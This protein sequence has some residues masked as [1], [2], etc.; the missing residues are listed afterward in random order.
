M[1]RLANF[2]GGQSVAPASGKYVELISPVTGLAFAE[3]PVSNEA[4]VDHAFAVAS[5]AFAAWKRTTPS[6][7][8]TQDR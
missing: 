5:S 6:E 8:S 1:R 7:R 2:I 4:D 3:A